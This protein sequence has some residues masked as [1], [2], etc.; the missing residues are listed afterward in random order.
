MIYDAA[1][2]RLSLDVTLNQIGSAKADALWFLVSTGSNPATA[3]HAIV[4]V[5]GMTRANPCVSIYRYD[6]GTWDGRAGR[7]RRI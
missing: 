4:Y 7:R 6:A 5:N 3:D 1:L 2:N